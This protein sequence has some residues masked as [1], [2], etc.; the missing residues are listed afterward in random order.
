VRNGI[1]VERFARPRQR[2]FDGSPVIGAV[3]RLSGGEGP[4]V[5]IEAMPEVLRSHPKARLVLVGYGALEGE[6]RGRAA[7]LG[8]DRS[9]TFTG[10][11]DSAEMLPSFDLFVQP[12]LYESQGLAL[13]EAMAAGVP[14]IATDVGGVGDV[15]RDGE[16]GLLVPSA[17]PGALARAI[18]RLAGAP[19]L[20]L[21]LSRKAA[22][23]VRDHFSS[24]TMLDAYARCT[25]GAGR[26]DIIRPVRLSNGCLLRA[27]QASGGGRGGGY[28]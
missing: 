23:H 12:S 6:L 21:D 7:S 17:D 14:S 28:Q 4:L 26:F 1:D 8:L 27:S 16:T 13:L 2:A 15:V 18:V 24:Q 3:G 22:R 11:Q 20:G 9:V 10:E 25:G 5:P 19:A